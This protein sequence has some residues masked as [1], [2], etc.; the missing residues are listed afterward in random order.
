MAREL[1]RLLIPPSRWPGVGEPSLLTLEAA[2]SHYLA[3]VLRFRQGDR[4]AVIDGCGRLWSAVL[5]SGEQ[6]R[7]EQPP[8]APVEQALA[9]SPALTLAVAVPR[10]DAE[11]V[12]RMAAELGAA[13]LQPLIAARGVVR[14]PLPLERWAAIIR[15]ATEQ[16]ERLWL[17]ELAPPLSASRC[18]SEARPGTRLLATTRRADIPPLASWVQALWNNNPWE[19][20]TLAVGPEGGWSEEEERQALGAGWQMVTLGDSILRTST[21]AV[22]GLATLALLR[23]AFAASPL[24]GDGDC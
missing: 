24:E 22:A 15:E 13:R 17:P 8:E 14:E 1:R 10:R 20:V 2:E 19:P 6:L 5:E 23:P 3:R 16:C 21:A 11:L 18:W 12:W 7:L 4:L 9:T